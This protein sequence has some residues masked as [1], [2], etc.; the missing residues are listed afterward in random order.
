MKKMNIDTYIAENQNSRKLREWIN[1]STPSYYKAITLTKMNNIKSTSLKTLFY[2]DNNAV[3]QYFKTDV[4]KLLSY[5][6]SEPDITAV[7]NEKQNKYE[8]YQGHFNK[9]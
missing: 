7:L 1:G 5:Y 3:L 4:I 8:V 2:A 9:K 6:D